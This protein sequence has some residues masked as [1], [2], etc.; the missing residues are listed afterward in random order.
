MPTRKWSQQSRLESG[1]PYPLGATWDGLGVN[2]ALY[3][4]HATKV[5]LCLFD[6]RGREQ[7]R[8]ALPEYS[9]EIW[10]GYLPDARPGQRY[11]YRVHGPFEPDA[12]H[13]FNPNKLLLDPYAKQIAGELRW[14]PHL[15]GY[16]LGH[17][18]QDR[19]FDRRDSAPYMPR[20]VVI[21]PAFTWGRER[22]PAVL[23]A[24][25]GSPFAAYCGQEARELRAQ[26]LDTVACQ[27]DTL[28]DL[29]KPR[30]K[31][32]VT[33]RFVRRTRCERCESRL[34][35]HARTQTQELARAARQ[36]EADV[37]A[38]LEEA[39]LPLPLH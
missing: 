34:H 32:K 14:A 18:D 13:R 17:R 5:E 2:F 9:D 33:L 38:A 28:D 25:C 15:F 11:G 8:I 26:R 20:C 6:E 12:G 10:H 22:A 23:T 31:R 16:T 1:R 19:S 27:R 7:E 39:D 21:D 29:E 3:S 24:D 4:R 36:I 37:A 35:V 30:G